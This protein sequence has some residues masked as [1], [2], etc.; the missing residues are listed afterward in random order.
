MAETS[1]IAPSFLLTE[2]WK[3]ALGERA[4]LEGLLSFLKPA[5]AI[6]VGTSMGGSLERLSAH[7][8][9]VHSFDLER[10]A[11][12]ATDRFPNVVFHTGDS[13]ELLAPVLAQL[14]ESGH[15]VNFALVDGDHSAVGV[16]RDVED[17]LAAPCVRRAVILLHDTM[18]DRVRAGL[19]E[20]ELGARPKV[21]LVDLDFVPGFLVREGRNRNRLWGGLGLVVVGYGRLEPPLA[22]HPATDAFSVF[23]VFRRGNISSEHL[24]FPEYAVLEQQIAVLERS[25]ETMRRSLSWRSTAPLRRARAFL[26]P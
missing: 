10:P 18:N 5:L 3:M 21:S 1:S 4:A 7:S 15:D 16:Q 25:L 24:P 11:A 17:L 14:S 9:V 6:E 2:Q 20:L 12:L 19:A 26:R 13:H 23:D 22:A 8:G